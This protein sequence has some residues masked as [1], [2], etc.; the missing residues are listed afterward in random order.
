MENFLSV[1]NFIAERKIQ[2]AID[3]HEFDNLDGMGKSL[4]LEDLSNI[5]ESSRMA[6]K[7]LKNSGYVPAEIADR[8]EAANVL[9]LLEN[10]ADEK[11]KLKYMYKLR[12]IMNKI[13]PGG[14]LALESQDEY[15][16]KILASLE[17]YERRYLRMNKKD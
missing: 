15:Y 14:H 4:D 12:L 10:S 17:R 11:L 6:Y 1:L 16:Q 8:K 7:I 13:R 9:E 3:N 2:E 5:P